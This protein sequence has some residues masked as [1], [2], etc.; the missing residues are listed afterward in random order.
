MTTT[1]GEENEFLLFRERV[2][3]DFAVGEGLLKRVDLVFR[4][5]G[6]GDVEFL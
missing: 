3:A 1:T 4:D 5:F 6:G 2:V